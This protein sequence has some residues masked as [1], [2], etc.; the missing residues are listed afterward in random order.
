MNDNIIFLICAAPVPL[1]MLIIG[2][3][4]WKNPP[5]PGSIGYKTTRA[6]S[7]DEAWYFAQTTW[8]RLSFVHNIFSLVGTLAACIAGI[9][10]NLSEEHGLILYIG[11]TVVQLVVIFA[12]IYITENRLRKY[13]NPDGTQKKF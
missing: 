10:L 5:S 7:S 2:I 13:F 9:L 12:D 6:Y 11:V 3:V 1:V 4:M 8:G